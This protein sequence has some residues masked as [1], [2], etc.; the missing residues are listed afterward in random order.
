M[1]TNTLKPYD[2]LS[3]DQVRQIHDHA[4]LILQEIGVDFLHPHAIETF[5]RA[6]LKAD[7]N[8]IHFER[9]FIEEQIKKVPSSFQVQARNPENTVTIG[10]NHIVNAPVYGPPFITDLDRGRRG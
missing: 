9:A 2:L 4:M 7:D 10:G 3:E 6:G 8:R 1:W 5:A